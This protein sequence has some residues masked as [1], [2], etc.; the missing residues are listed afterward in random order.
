MDELVPLIGLLSKRK[1][2]DR[3]IL[4]SPDRS[5]R[6]KQDALFLAIKNGRVRTDEG[7][8]QLL[9]GKTRNSQA[10]LRMKRRL[11]E[12]LYNSVV[13]IDQDKLQYTSRNKAGYKV[14]KQYV[15]ASLLGAE[16]ENVLMARMLERLIGHAIRYELTEYVK[17]IAK[18]LVRHYSVRILDDAKIQRFS[19]I[20]TRYTEI[21]EFE[22][23]ANVYY[24][25]LARMYR[26]KV[27]KKGEFLQKLQ[28]Y[29]GELARLQPGIDTF[30]FNL[31]AFSINSTRL[32]F[33]KQYD[34]AI[35]NAEAALAFFER[36]PFESMRDRFSFNSDK[37]IACLL[38]GRYQEV[39]SLL[40][41]TRSQVKPFGINF[42][43]L[44]FYQF[45]NY[46]L[47]KEY[48]KLP[49]ILDIVLG[50]KE[51]RKYNTQYEL[52]RIR[53]AYTRFLIEAEVIAP[54]PG[55]T[56]RKPFRLAKFL[57]E[58]PIYSREKRGMNI[59]I[60]VIQMLYYIRRKKYNV[61]IDRIDALKQYSFRYLRNDDTFRSNCFIKMLAKIPQLDFHPYRTRMHTQE[62]YQRLL[63]HE[64]DIQEL[65][66]EIE[67]IPF[68]DLWPI[69]LE[70]LKKNQ[71][72]VRKN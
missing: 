12:K 36:K 61:V 54:P 64:I 39:E 52:W 51:I 42:F 14:M 43:T 45:Q 33:L 66:N 10:Y 68:N 69:V 4:K 28:L 19:A 59:A 58:V 72:N 40:E 55:E 70:V 9:Y 7:A 27:S 62:L 49:E 71:K 11:R 56:D 13:T 32:I 63:K 6:N 35:E 47:S 37:I 67:V 15:V 20:Y 18:Q 50:S 57:N 29:G 41:S 21:E 1:I 26:Q 38:T 60:L 2:S 16:G 22:F 3:Y 8:M 44:Y 23:R 31:R 5:G 17:L 65:T 30:E 53:E 34:R 25:E 24:F 46:F 48:G